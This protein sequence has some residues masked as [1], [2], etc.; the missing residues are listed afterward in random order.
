MSPHS[1]C[2][3]SRARALAAL[4]LVILATL[5]LPALARPELRV[6]ADV[7]F[8]N[9]GVVRS[10]SGTDIAG[11][12]RD[13]AGQ[14]VPDADLWIQLSSIVGAAGSCPRGAAVRMESLKAFV[15]TDSLGSFCIRLPAGT[16]V[17]DLTLNYAGDTYHGSATG[18]IPV[19]TGHRR[20]ALAVDHRELVASLDETSFVAWVDA[21]ASDGF[22]VGDPVR[23]VLW[24]QSDPAAPQETEVGATDVQVGASQ[25][26]I[27][28][29]RRPPGSG[30]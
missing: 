13:D 7:A 26:C 4:S 30:R 23:L 29:L 10:E 8:T 15:R 12:L 16:A 20:L 24:H 14:P 27:A 2:G 3:I 25:R 9:V 1:A 21:T 11:G 5:S 28:A 18:P 6:R 19:T 22:G 17:E